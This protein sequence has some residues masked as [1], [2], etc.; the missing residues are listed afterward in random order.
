MPSEKPGTASTSVWR[1]KSRNETPPT[2]SQI[3]SGDSSLDEEEAKKVVE[4]NE[5]NVL[6]RKRK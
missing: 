3:S 5:Q 1:G 4:E 2:D 6:D